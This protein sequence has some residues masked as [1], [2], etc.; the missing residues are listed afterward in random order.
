MAIGRRIA[1][2]DGVGRLRPSAPT[3]SSPFI[4]VG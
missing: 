4:R 1:A 2:A 3:I